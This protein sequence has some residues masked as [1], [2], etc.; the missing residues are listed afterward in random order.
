MLAAATLRP[1]VMRQEPDRHPLV[2]QLRHATD[3][4]AGFLPL[5]HPR[6]I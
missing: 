3:R 2:E 5:P 6:L 1:T 4:K